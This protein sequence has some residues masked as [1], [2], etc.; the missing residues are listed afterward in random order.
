MLILAK[1]NETLRYYINHIED[2]KA[3]EKYAE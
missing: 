1:F 3:M 2:L